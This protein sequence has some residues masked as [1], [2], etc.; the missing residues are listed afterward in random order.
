MAK[1]LEELT[2]A[3]SDLGKWQAEAETIIKAQG[4]FIKAQG[5]VQFAQ[6]ELLKEHAEKIKQLTQTIGIVQGRLLEKKKPN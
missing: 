2:E 4:E 3:I 1:T 6:G 5:G